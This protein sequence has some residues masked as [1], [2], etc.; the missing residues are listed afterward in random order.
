[1][2]IS[3]KNFNKEETYVMGILNV[4]P[5]SFFDGGK[6]SNASVALKQ[7]E[8]MV[9]EGAD[10]IDVGG[11]STKPGFSKISANEEIER[12]VPI[13]REIRK[14]F[15]IPLSIDTF[16]SEVAKAALDEGCG[17]VNDIFGFKFDADMPK[18]V[19]S[20]NAAVCLTHNRQN[21]NY[22]SLIDDIISDLQQSIKMAKLE[23]IADNKIL[24][25]CGIGFQKDTEQ[26]LICVK[27][28]DK[29]NVLGYGQVLGASNKSFIGDVL[30]TDIND[31]KNGT[32]A[33]TVFGVLANCMFIRVHDVLPN[34][35][36]IKMTKSILGKK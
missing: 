36:V 8:K 25:D 17:M 2:K 32:L 15:D 16:K 12:V 26:N 27:N 35:N 7:T 30:G 19:K 34:K 29:F 10:I 31:R 20:Y 11:Q 28:L 14:N 5:D 33:T 13:I 9:L 4:T 18:I 21:S 1:M 23:N 24:I 22:I 3:G 6:Y